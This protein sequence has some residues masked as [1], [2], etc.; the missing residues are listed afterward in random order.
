MKDIK[1]AIFDLDGTILD[2]MTIWGDIAI[3][4]LKSHGATP[5]DTIRED[6]RAT[7]TV[8]EAEHY[9]KHY[10]INKS[11]EDVIHG[12]DSM[13]LKRY[14]TDVKVKSGVREV[15]EALK[16]RGVKICLATA[17]ERNLAE[18]AIKAHGL[19]GYFKHIFTCT[20]ENTSKK[21]PDI[22]NKAAEFLGTAPHETLII[23]DALYAAKT[24]KRAGFVTIGVYDF[25]SDNIQDELREVCDYYFVKMDE[26]LEV[27]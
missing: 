27:L 13:M 12:R 23:E 21:F 15:L 10:G 24:A 20:E 2:S 1:G 22:Y 19:D 3:D 26:M 9:I 17:T 25:V 14:M 8:E 5:R 6:L 18:P 4:Y 16:N 7:N 11:V